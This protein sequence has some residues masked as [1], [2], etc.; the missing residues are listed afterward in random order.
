MFAIVSKRYVT[1]RASANTGSREDCL[2][3]HG[4]PV[5][6]VEL[7]KNKIRATSLEH[8]SPSLEVASSVHKIDDCLP[9]ESS[10]TDI[11]N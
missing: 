11:E 5:S 9:H 7:V 6:T 3:Q 2:A 4:C 10:Y 1:S 8:L